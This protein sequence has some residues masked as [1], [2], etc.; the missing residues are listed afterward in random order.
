VSGEEDDV[1]PFVNGILKSIAETPFGKNLD[2]G[3]FF[4]T[5]SAGIAYYPYNGTSAA[6][7][8][9][10]ADGAVRQ[11]KTNGKN[12]CAPAQTGYHY[13][14]SGVIDELRWQKLMQL[15]NRTGMS[16]ETLI[17]EG[18]ESLFQKHAALYRFCCQESNEEET[19]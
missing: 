17:R 4:V 10:L 14:Q 12:S 15:C 7:L 1:S 6:A 19:L 18:Y 11:A 16:A 5:Y 9:D 8:L 3:P 2:K 13:I